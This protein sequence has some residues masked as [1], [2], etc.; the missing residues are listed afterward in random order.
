M[1]ISAFPVDLSASPFLPVGSLKLTDW[2]ARTFP[3]VHIFG[4]TYQGQV[5][6]TLHF[7]LLK[8]GTPVLAPFDGSILQVFDQPTSCD[9]EVHLAGAGQ[10]GNHLLSYDHVLPLSRFRTK[11]ATFRAGEPI[12]SVG[13]WEC[14][15]DFGRVELM[16]ITA[17]AA[18]T[19]A[20][21]RCPLMLLDATKRSAMLAQLATVMAWWNSLSPQTP[22]T[23][24][25]LA[26]PMGLCA[27]EFV[28]L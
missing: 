4:R 1:A 18:G 16:V 14:T 17:Q 2:P 27:V 24:T 19:P 21:A 20:R 12:A 23:S 8:V 10:N 6:P 26:N 28:P 9:A 11:G 5:E 22:Y 15:L 3:P 25:E 13:A 7:D